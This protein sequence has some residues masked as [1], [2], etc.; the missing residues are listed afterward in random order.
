MCMMIIIVMIMIT[1]TILSMIII[2]IIMIMIIIEMIMI[3][4]TI[5]IIIIT[6]IATRYFTMHLLSDTALMHTYSVNIYITLT[7]YINIFV[8]CFLKNIVIMPFF[9]NVFE[10]VYISW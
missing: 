6:I 4:I 5:E 3:I 10:T 8:N 1:M 7:K 9:L 2:I